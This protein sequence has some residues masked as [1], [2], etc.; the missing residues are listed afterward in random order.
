MELSLMELQN[1][2]WHDNESIARDGKVRRVLD[3]GE[4]LVM[5]LEDRN[6]VMIGPR[7]LGKT[8]ALKY[9]IYRKI[10]KEGVNPKSILYYSFD[11]ARDYSVISEVIESFLKATSGKRYLYLD[12]VSFVEGWQRPVK[13]FLDSSGS[14]DVRI[15][16][17]GSASI[18]LRKELF[19]GRDIMIREFL[20]SLFSDFVLAFASE[21][22]REFIRSNRSHDLATV[23]AHTR[24]AVLYFKELDR[25]FKI[26]IQTGGFPLP[27]LDHFATGSITES[28]FDTHWN[29][30]LSDISKAERSVETS[31]AI[32]QELIKSYSSKIN[33]SKLARNAGI[34]SHVT[35]REYM[36][37]L[38]ELFIV[39]Y[40]FP[41]S[42]RGIPLFRKERK[43]YFTDPFLFNL[44]SR[45]LNLP[46]AGT[47]PKVVEGIVHS[48][49]SRT[50]T[51][52]GYVQKDKETDFVSKGLSLEVKWQENVTKLDIPKSDSTHNIVLSKATSGEGIIPVAVFLSLLDEKGR[53]DT[54]V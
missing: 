3:S 40:I 43:A 11:T 8:T 1:P 7:Q 50:L 19:P 28:T 14:K 23:I 49:L 15:Y 38:K 48:H 44:F 12:E 53:H 31:T 52:I 13:F 16:V 51:G 47:E 21:D 24:K 39:E 6:T 22:L 9:D 54:I 17:T 10:E 18:N 20:S 45:K 2:W 37:L 36:E 35:A 26:F 46:T 5:G 41:I 34:P 4:K 29:A 42:D 33:M 30:F 32:I 25:L 27:V